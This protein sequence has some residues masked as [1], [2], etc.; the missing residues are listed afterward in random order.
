MGYFSYTQHLTLTLRKL[1]VDLLHCIQMKLIQIK[2]RKKV[3]K[4]LHGERK[5]IYLYNKIHRRYIDSAK[6]GILLR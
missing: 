6:F 5:T 3:K 4:L 1:M 2:M